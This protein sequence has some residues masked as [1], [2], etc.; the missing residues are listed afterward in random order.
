MSAANGVVDQPDGKVQRVIFDVAGGNRHCRL[1]APKNDR[2]VE[3][4]FRA[5]IVIVNLGL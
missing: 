5:W 3:C 1:V 2:A 4:P